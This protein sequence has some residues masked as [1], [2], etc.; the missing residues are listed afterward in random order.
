MVA[1]RVGGK[2]VEE[3]RG[4]QSWPNRDPLVMK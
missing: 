2:V 1:R 3:V 4:E